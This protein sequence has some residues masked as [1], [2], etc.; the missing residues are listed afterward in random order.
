MTLQRQTKN[1]KRWQL[2]FKDYSKNVDKADSQFFWRL[3]DDI[4]LTIIKQHIP[5]GL[6][7]QFTILDAGGGTGR[8]IEKLANLYP[9]ANFLLYDK[10]QDML[11][12]AKRKRS[13]KKLKNDGRL[14]IIMGDIQNMAEIPSATIDYIISIY[15]PISFIPRPVLFF[16]EAFRVLKSKGKAL[17]M[18]QGFYNAIYSKI[19]NYLADA[20]ELA[21]LEKNKKVIWNPNIPPSNLFSKEILEDLVKR[22]SFRVNRLYGI[23]IFAQPG[24]EDFDPENKKRSRI[25]QKLESDPAFYQ[26]VFSLEMKYNALDSLIN[27]GMNLLIVVQK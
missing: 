22:A 24:E 12:T 20:N 14:E 27:R 15:N 11:N 23:P 6:N 5:L 3:S 10:S 25:S 26:Q 1:N 8:W 17:I 2:F 19:N 16:R 7:R 9:R 13:L 4:I 21:S 18:G